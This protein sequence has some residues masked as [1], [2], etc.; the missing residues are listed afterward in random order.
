MKR[1]SRILPCVLAVLFS[2]PLFGQQQNGTITG[3]V[4]DRDGKT[5]L[6]GALVVI[7]QLATNNGRIMVRETLQTKTGRDGRSSLACLYI[8]RLRVSVIVNNQRVMSKGDAIGDE[9]YLATGLDTVANFDLS[10]AP[11]APPAAAGGDTPAAPAN[12]KEREELRKKLE[13][14]AA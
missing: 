8:G 3:R 12:D 4:L 6:V 7:D 5:P 11:A 9:L 2:V 14:Q 10:K 1:L 13:E